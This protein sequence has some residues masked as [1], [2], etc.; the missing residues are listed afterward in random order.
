MELRLLGPLL[1]AGLGSVVY[2]HWTELRGVG[3][4]RPYAAVQFF[5]ILTILPGQTDSSSTIRSRAIASHLEL[6]RTS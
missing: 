2:W 6:K 5:P 1:L 4:L 3:D